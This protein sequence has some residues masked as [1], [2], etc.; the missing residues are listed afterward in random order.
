MAS[1][2]YHISSLLEKMTSTDKDFRCGIAARDGP[3]EEGA[4]QRGA[5]SPQEWVCRRPEICISFIYGVSSR[6]SPS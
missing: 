6:L 2:S 3:W 5:L 4:A 1:V